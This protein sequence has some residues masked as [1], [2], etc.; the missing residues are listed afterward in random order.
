MN[1]LGLASNF[2]PILEKFGLFEI[3][4]YKSIFES[5]FCSRN[6][7]TVV[8][9]VEDI[10]GAIEAAPEPAFE[11]VGEGVDGE[12]HL[13]SMELQYLKPYLDFDKSGIELRKTSN[14]GDAKNSVK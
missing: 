14:G 10:L 3:E 5:I 6:L 7:F 8:E 4:R 13:M 1:P 12:E 2:L 9:K 11:D